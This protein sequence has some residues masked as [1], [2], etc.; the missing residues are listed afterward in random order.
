MRSKKPRIAAAA[1]IV[2]GAIEIELAAYQPPSVAR[3]PSPTAARSGAFSLPPTADL[4]Y[5]YVMAR[6]TPTEFNW[7]RI[8]WLA[9][10]PEALHQAKAE[11]RPIL[12][13]LSGD[14]P[15]DRC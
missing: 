11:N 4:F 7:Q 13:W 15:L 5:R 10:Y 2:M 12:L 8:P 3:R 1:L 6:R 14:D 9:D